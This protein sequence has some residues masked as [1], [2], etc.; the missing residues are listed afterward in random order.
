MTSYQSTCDVVN[1]IDDVFHFMSETKIPIPLG[2]TTARAEYRPLHILEEAQEFHAAYKHLRA[3][4]TRYTL[5]ELRTVHQE[6]YVKAWVDVLDGL[7]DLIYVSVGC[8]HGLGLDPV[9]AWMEV[10]A[11]NM[12]KIQYV[13]CPT[14]DG[15]GLLSSGATCPHCSTS[16][17]IPGVKKVVLKNS[18]GK[19]LKPV[20]W[21]P[22]DLE[23][24]VRAQLN[25][26][27]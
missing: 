19:V 20:G 6:E 27:K 1:P 7:I 14:C 24:I 13:D 15:I 5:E 18:E 25:L 10:H 11:A 26:L 17:G 2:P 8:A 16:S 22:P 21:E 23:T 3:L 9:P 12:R 4:E